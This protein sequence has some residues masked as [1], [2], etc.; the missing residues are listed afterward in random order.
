MAKNMELA[1]KIASKLDG[2]VIGNFKKTS[3]EMKKMQEAMKKVKEQE[4]ALA[5]SQK[6]QENLEKQHKAY[7]ILN[8][9]MQDAS[10]KLQAMKKAYED[11]GK[12]NKELSN[13]IKSQEKVVNNLNKQVERQKNVFHAA[14]SELESSKKD[15]DKYTTSLEKAKSELEQF[16][17]KQSETKRLGELSA[18]MTSK[19]TTL[20]DKGRSNMT[21]GAVTLAAAAMPIK[22]Y[23]EVEEAQADLKKMID[24]TSQEAD[25]FYKAF[26]DMSDNS[27]LSQVDIFN[28]A[29][30]GAQAGIA[31]N[32]LKEFTQDASKIKVA[33]D[34]DS[35]AAGDFLAKTRSQLSLS[36]KEV[37]RFAD[38][39]NYLADNT[40]AQAVDI[41]D[42]SQRVG[43]LARTAGVSKESNIAYGATLLSMGKTSEVA[44]TGLKQLYLELSKGADTNKKFGAYKALGLD[45]EKLKQ[46]M[47]TDA[48]GAIMT[49]LN[50]LN[51]VPKADK[52][53]LINT[54]FGEQAIDSIST[55]SNE[56]GTLAENIK[57]AHSAAAKGSVDKEYKNRMSTTLNAL[58]QGFNQVHNVFADLGKALAPS[59]LQALNAMKP[60]VKSVADFVT[61]HPKL[62]AGIMKAIVAFGAFKLALGGGQ[63]LFGGLFKSI[64]SGINLFSKFKN[65]GGLTK[66]MSLLKGLG[67]GGA[68][69]FKLLGKGGL[70]ALKGIGSVA[71]LLGGGLVKG[72]MGF[73][74]VIKLVGTAIRMAFIANPVGMIVMAIIAV[75]AIMILLYN[76]CAWFRNFVNKLWKN[77][78]TWG[79]Q[80]WA[81]IKFAAIQ[82]WAQ[83]RPIFMLLVAIA[84]NNFKMIWNVAK[85][86]FKM[87]GIFI[88]TAVA[89]WKGIFSIFFAIFTGQW[90]K[91]PG[92]VT[93]IWNS[94]KSGVNTFI[95]AFKS[96]FTGLFDW[97]GK[98][99]ENVKKTAGAI[100]SAINPGSWFGGKK[101]NFSGTRNWQGGMT[102]VAEKGREFIQLP[103]GQGFI[104]PFRTTMNLPKGT[105]ILN[106]SAT[107][108]MFKPQKTG[109]LLDRVQK[110]KDTISNSVASST[111]GATGPINITINVNSG[112]GNVATDI[113][114]EVE[115]V[116]KQIQSKQLR[117]QF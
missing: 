77:V 84:V 5:S 50:A 109:S 99:W 4:K 17:K 42:I 95:S 87:I 105:K 88:K 45:G 80:A 104:A 100:A 36:Q 55:L 37:M 66:S 43:G 91:I 38:S 56:T 62:V 82:M 8:K 11:S 76:K 51:K 10:K 89:V 106:N 97:F 113:A 110:V 69:A 79:L 20:Q 14:R 32:Q 46:Q 35:A 47:A 22:A 98:Q 67:K 108:S 25:G 30:A 33:F 52:A 44:S 26:R 28:I 12:S 1:F 18:N 74:K 41:V 54:L 27:N 70:S 15:V 40:A 9:D 64:G 31:K 92:L 116:I 114:R 86:V 65:M 16:N 63:M 19:G 49:V 115:K 6:V 102:E 112:D 72:I 3:D 60:F 81:R 96:L 58:K 23:V 103:T 94:I 117:T 13:V 34:M 75:I 73:V 59:I 48:D 53:G 68:T 29:G 83:I 2:S 107:E 90:N 111:N 71:K 61:K 57:K 7:I 21:T 39:I 101:G 93:G 24:F 78:A 85:S